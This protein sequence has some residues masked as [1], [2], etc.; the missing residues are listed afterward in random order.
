MQLY[1]HD[2]YVVLKVTRGRPEVAAVFNESEHA[3]KFVEKIQARSPGTYIFEKSALYDF[4]PDQVTPCP[5]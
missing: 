5:A 2:V 4:G 3:R 1:Q